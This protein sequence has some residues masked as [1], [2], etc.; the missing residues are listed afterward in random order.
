MST[1]RTTH[2]RP[3][4][5]DEQPRRNSATFP[6]GGP[7]CTPEGRAISSCQFHEA[8]P[9]HRPGLHPAR[10]RTPLH[11]THQLRFATNSPPTA[12]SNSISSPKSAAPCGVCAVA[13]KSKPTSPSASTIATAP[14]STPWKPPTQDAAK[15]QLSVDRA[16]SQAHRLLHKSTAELRRLQTE[17][18]YRNLVL[19]SR[20]HTRFLGVCN[21]QFRPKQD[22]CQGYFPS[23]AGNTSPTLPRSTPCSRRHSRPQ[24]RQ[25]RF[26]RPRFLRRQYRRKRPATPIAP[27]NPA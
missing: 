19:R 20:H 21:L 3:L 7:P 9:L 13:A 2:R 18:Q 27:A 1:L 4:Q 22:R 25:V 24:T 5:Y 6:H 16:R 11:R 10:R 14:P 23:T 17:R 8:R 26:V 15:A 12:R